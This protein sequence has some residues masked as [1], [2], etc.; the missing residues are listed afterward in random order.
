MLKEMRSKFKATLVEY[1]K[2]SKI[3]I[4]VKSLLY[5][6]A[7]IIPALFIKNIWIILFLGVIWSTLELFLISIETESF[8]TKIKKLKEKIKEQSELERELEIADEIN[9]NH[10]KSFLIF[11][12]NELKLLRSERI[13]VYYRNEKN[14][15]FEIISRYSLNPSYISKGRQ[16]Y[17][18]DKGFI[19]KCW[20]GDSEDFIKILSEVGTEEYYT[21]QD[22]V[23]YTRSEI[24]GLTMK[25]RLFY[26]LNVSK[27]DCPS[28]GVVVIE[29]TSDK[30]DKYRRA[31]EEE[32]I[33][34][35]LRKDMLRY[36]GLLYDLMDKKIVRKR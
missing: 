32:R 30:L 23:G 4:I 31:V 24:D 22:A 36:I 6:F 3:T 34:E 10:L 18:K 13:S 27:P 16:S 11:L 33:R 2:T 17:E 20:E 28:I 21:E 15:D 19:A 14:S 9:E 5:L 35:L 12:T 29:S 26:V 8:Q 1:W 25:P 7:T